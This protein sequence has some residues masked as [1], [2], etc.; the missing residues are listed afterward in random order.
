MSGSPSEHTPAKVSVL[1]MGD[2]RHAYN[3]KRQPLQ[4]QGRKESEAPL[5]EIGDG[6]RGNILL[7]RAVPMIL[8]ATAGLSTSLQ[9][10]G[11]EDKGKNGN[12]A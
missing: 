3:T 1:K 11:E 12:G 4:R 6:G 7:P 8:L 10:K 9:P 5:P 2:P